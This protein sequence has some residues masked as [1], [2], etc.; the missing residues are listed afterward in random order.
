MLKAL[1]LDLDETLCDTLGANERAKQ[2]MARDI[3]TQYGVNINGQVFADEY[4]AGIYREWSDDQRAR[5]MPIIEQQSEETFRLQLIRDLLAERAVDNIS[6]DTAKAH[7]DKFDSDRLKAFDFYPG[8]VDFLIEARKMF[9]LVVI[10]NGPEF[11]QVPKVKQVNLAEYVDH[12]IIG[13]QEP[14]QKPAASI[15][16]KALKLANCQASEAVHVG[17]S[18]AA[19]IAGA[20]NS[21]ITSVW[22]QH[23][24]PLDA[25]LGINPHHIVLHPSEIP[26]LIHQL[27][28]G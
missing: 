21:G 17:D 4:V 13:G 5:Y 24:Q 11:S 9:I 6:D 19:D 27:H 1:F 7:Q 15:F 26:G 25:E 20:H 14:E 18:L 23:Q 12:I 28:Q 2:L 22:I 16:N 10:T 3:E 8:I